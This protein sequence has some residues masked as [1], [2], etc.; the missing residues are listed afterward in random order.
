M[1]RGF[2]ATTARQ[3]DM[4]HKSDREQLAFAAEREMVVVT[5]DRVDFEDLAQ[6]YFSEGCMHA[7]I[8]I[9]VER[10]V[11]ALVDRLVMLLDDRTADE[12]KNQ[13]IYI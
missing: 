1:G 7:G 5:H 13:I 2:E 9:A 12:L 11:F 4:L 10:P 8:I 6:R 3:L